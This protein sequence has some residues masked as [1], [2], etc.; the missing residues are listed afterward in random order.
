M[1]D[2]IFIKK[3]ETD[4]VCITNIKNDETFGFHLILI[5]ILNS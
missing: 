3:K 5:R 2:K 4:F 1:N